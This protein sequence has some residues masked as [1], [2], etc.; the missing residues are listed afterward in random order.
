MRSTVRHSQRG[1]RRDVRAFVQR[2]DRVDQVDVMKNNCARFLYER[3]GFQVI[4]Q[5]EHKLEMRWQENEY[6]SESK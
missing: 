2:P 1:E 4:G 3:L 5:S 6:G